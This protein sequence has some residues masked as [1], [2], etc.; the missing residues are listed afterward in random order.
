MEKFAVGD[1]VRWCSLLRRNAVDGLGTVVAL[2]GE[3][4]VGYGPYRVD[5][6][7]AKLE[8]VTVK[9]DCLRKRRDVAPQ[10]LRKLTV[11]D[12]IVEAIGN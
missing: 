12:E 3:I 5:K 7:G 4:R 11:L 2:P 9:W 6:Y 10:H 1:R 8:I